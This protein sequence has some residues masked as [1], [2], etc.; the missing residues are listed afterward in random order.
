MNGWARSFRVR[1]GGG[2]DRAFFYI[3]TT[4]NRQPRSSK[5]EIRRPKTHA[6]GYPQHTQS[7]LRLQLVVITLHGPLKATPSIH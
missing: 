2:G 4:R 3:P 5:E 7:G 1:S 6:S